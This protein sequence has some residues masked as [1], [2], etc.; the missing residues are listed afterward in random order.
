M[1]Y[2]EHKMTFVSAEDGEAQIQVE[3]LRKGIVNSKEPYSCLA[4]QYM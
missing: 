1:E 2:T 4:R 3:R